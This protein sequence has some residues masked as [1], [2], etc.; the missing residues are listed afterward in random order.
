MKVRALLACAVFSAAC[1]HAPARGPRTQR[2]TGEGWAPITASD[3]AGTRRRALASALREAVEK[4]AGVQLTA[5][6]EVDR[7]MA[8][9]DTITARTRGTLRSYQLLSEIEEGGFHKTRVSALVE[10][11]EPEDGAPPLPLAGDPKV[12]VALTG[13]NAS[14]AASGVRRSLIARGFT[15]VDGERA[16]ITVR[17]TVALNP[18]GLVGPFSSSRARVALEARQVRT[19]RVL[20]ASGRVASGVGAGPIEAAAKASETAGL[21]GGEEIASQV[22]ARLA[23]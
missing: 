16:D 21:L 12:S 5:K 23:E 14:D 6:T 13:P 11:D 3:P 18:K 1:A 20:W 15:V 8:V 4:A 22:A 9:E 2:S 7:A 17:G 19:G 10:L